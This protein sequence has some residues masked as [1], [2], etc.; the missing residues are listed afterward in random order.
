MKVTILTSLI[1]LK[2]KAI[3]LREV[4]RTVMIKAAVIK[5]RNLGHSEKFVS[6]LFT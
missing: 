2:F 6:D 5:G 3:K 1:S 4:W